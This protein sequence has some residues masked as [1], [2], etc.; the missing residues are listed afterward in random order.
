MDSSL[1]SPRSRLPDLHGDEAWEFF[2]TTFVENRN[3]IRSAVFALLR[4][5][6][7]HQCELPGDIAE[8]LC[9]EDAQQN[10]PGIVS[11]MQAMRLEER[12]D[13]LIAIIRANAAFQRLQS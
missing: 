9:L 2:R 12:E 4:G 8:A 5:C 6:T 13:L 3:F 10:L 11:K 7:E 1:V